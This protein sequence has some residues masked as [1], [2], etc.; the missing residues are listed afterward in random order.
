[1]TDA[2]VDDEFPEGMD[3]TDDFDSD[4]PEITVDFSDEEAAS[5]AL[6]ALPSGKYNVEITKVELKR[7]QSDKNPGKPYYSIVMRVFEGPYTKRTVYGNVMLW[8]GA[9]YSLNQL[10]NATGF[11]T[12]SGPNRVPSPQEL[13]GKRLTIR[14][15]KVPPK[16]EYDEKFEVKGY[17]PLKDGAVASAGAATTSLEP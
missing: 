1:M 13:I 14:G 16:G 4:V 6:E 2:M 12:K 17:M 9:A 3:P 11:A 10:M 7:S 8:Q 15:V 5:K